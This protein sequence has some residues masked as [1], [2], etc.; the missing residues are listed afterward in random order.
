[1]FFAVYAR[2]NYLYRPLCANDRSPA[3]SNR[4]I[5]SARCS[6]TRYG[7]SDSIRYGTRWSTPSS[8]ACT[9]TR[10]A[11]PRLPSRRSRPTNSGMSQ[12]G[13][14][15]RRSP[16]PR[17]ATSCSV[18]RTSESTS[19]G[20]GSSTKGPTGPVERKSKNAATPKSGS[21]TG[22]STYCQSVTTSDGVSRYSPDNPRNHRRLDGHVSPPRW[23]QTG[24]GWTCRR[25]LSLCFSCKSEVF[26]ARRA[27]G[28][29]RRYCT[30]S[31]NRLAFPRTRGAQG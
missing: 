30:G 12:R 25:D 1:M 6:A 29:I 7:R 24:V 27:G 16:T 8:R 21:C 3:I 5:V 23:C 14:A 20:T 13:R 17:C 4:R 31:Q 2:S 11:S 22:R 9:P 28:E 18:C 10:W 15:S 26:L 19:Y